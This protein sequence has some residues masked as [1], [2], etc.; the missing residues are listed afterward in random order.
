MV[1][2]TSIKGMERGFHNSLIIILS[3]KINISA[4][5]NV[6]NNDKGQE[7]DTVDKTDKDEPATS[8]E[9]TVIANKNTSQKDIETMSEDKLEEAR[10]RIDG[11]VL[12][13]AW[14]L[15]WIT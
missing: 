7:N 11:K 15:N 5:G 13:R 10:E 9:E 1:S 2:A 4:L 8:C 6:S 14:A 3:W 12:E